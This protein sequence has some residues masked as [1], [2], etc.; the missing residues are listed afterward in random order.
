MN[1]RIHTAF[2]SLSGAW[3]C[4]PVWSSSLPLWPGEVQGGVGDYVPQ[5]FLFPL[6]LPH[7]A[8]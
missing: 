3:S 7:L 4:Y 2:E 6:T 1:P 5:V 8:G